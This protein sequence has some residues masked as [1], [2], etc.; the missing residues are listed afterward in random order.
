MSKAIKPDEIIAKTAKDLNI[1]EEQVRAVVDLFYSSLKT[2]VETMSYPRYN[3]PGLGV[4]YFGMRKLYGRMMHLDKMLKGKDPEDFKKLVQYKYDEELLEFI[5]ERFNNF[6]NYYKENGKIIN[7]VRKKEP[8]SDL[9]ESG[10]N[11]GGDPK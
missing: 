5:K 11:N 7:Y 3:I 9:E 4:L 2:K 1:P 8:A 10:A 6:D